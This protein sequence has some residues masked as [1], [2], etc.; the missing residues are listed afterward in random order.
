MP[1]NNSQRVINEFEGG[2]SHLYWGK[3]PHCQDAGMYYIVKDTCKAH[4]IF[5]EQKVTPTIESI[6][7]EKMTLYSEC[8]ECEECD[9][10]TCPRPV[11]EVGSKGSGMKAVEALEGWFID[12][13]KCTPWEECQCCKGT[14]YLKR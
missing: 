4:P 1:K 6:S 10:K 11:E 2:P 5:R 3:S 14:G 13:S 12:L 8:E 9:S 7:Y